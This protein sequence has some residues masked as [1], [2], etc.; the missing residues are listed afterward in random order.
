VA[1]NGP[2]VHPSDDIWSTGGMILKGK[3]EELEE[4][5]I[6]VMFFYTTYATWTDPDTNPDL[7]SERLA[8]NRPNLDTA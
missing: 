4:K 2:I 3:T 5:P 7:C 8:T 6:S 1:T